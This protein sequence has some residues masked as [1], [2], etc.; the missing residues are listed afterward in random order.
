MSV[1]PTLAVEPSPTLSVA[2]A[3]A[4]E[5]R[6]T[7]LGAPAIAVEPCLAPLEPDGGLSVVP[8]QSMGLQEDTVIEW[9]TLLRSQIMQHMET[10]D[11]LS[12]CPLTVFCLSVL[13]PGMHAPCIAPLHAWAIPSLTNLAT[14]WPRILTRFNPDIKPHDSRIVA[15]TILAVT[16]PPS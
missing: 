10:H 3:I 13:T 5:P 9:D 2:P 4:V 12:L 15:I 8:S 14:D 11:W 16:T 7:P 6:P 1:A